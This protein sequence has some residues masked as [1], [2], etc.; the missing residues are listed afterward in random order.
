MTGEQFMKRA[1]VLIIGA[2]IVLA[3]WWKT[4]PAAQERKTGKWLQNISKNYTCSI[5]GTGYPED[6]TDEINFCPNCGAQMEVQ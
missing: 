6:I 1:S 4:E 5:C 2:S 3:V